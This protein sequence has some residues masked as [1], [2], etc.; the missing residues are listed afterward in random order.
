LSQVPGDRETKLL[1]CGNNTFRQIGQMNN[2][3]CVGSLNA[4]NLIDVDQSSAIDGLLRE[5]TERHAAKV[6]RRAAIQWEVH[7]GTETIKITRRISRVESSVAK[8]GSLEFVHA[9]YLRHG[10]GF[11]GAVGS[12]YRIPS[13]DAGIGICHPENSSTGLTI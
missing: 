12:G 11:H 10:D 2:E 6:D 13:T 1:S 4:D 9:L 5:R 3:I 7:R 8:G